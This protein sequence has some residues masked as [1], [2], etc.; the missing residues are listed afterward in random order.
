[1][2]GADENGRKGMTT[3]KLSR[4]LSTRGTLQEL[5]YQNLKSA[6]IAGEFRPGQQLTVRAISESMSTSAMPAR[7]AIRR[8]AAERALEILPNGFVRVRLMTADQ[9][10]QLRQIRAALEGMA[11]RL[12]ADKI[13]KEEIKE[14]DAINKAMGEEFAR[15]DARAALIQ[16]QRF[17]FTIYRAARA[18]VLLDTI[19]LLWMQYGPFLRLYVEHFINEYPNAKKRNMSPHNDMIAAL[20]RHD[21]DAADRAIRQEILEVTDFMQARDEDAPEHGPAKGILSG[22][23]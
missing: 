10:A 18:D 14:L 6:L 9:R 13:S 17:H 23:V 16:N 15:K 7:E 3:F 11:A 5:V 21:G 12:A 22:A 4:P 20:R 19:E 2:G 8:L 1:M